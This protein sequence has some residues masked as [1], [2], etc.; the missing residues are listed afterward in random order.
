M[1]L[2]AIPVAYCAVGGIL[3][4]SGIKGATLSDT[5]RGI[6]SG[7]VNTIQATEGISINNSTTTNS[8][9]TPTGSSASGNQ[10]IGAAMGYNG[11]RYVFGGPSNPSSGW[12]CSSFASYVLGHDLGMLLPGNETWAKATNNGSTHGPVADEF[13]N[14]PRFT[15]VGNSPL[16]NQ[17]G[18]LLVWTGHVG[19]G[20]GNGGMFSAFDTQLGTLSTKASAPYSY[21]GTYRVG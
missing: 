9:A 3:V 17:P 10:I 16:N 11:H 18:D 1:A 13:A 14:T 8:G 2:K 5:A 21:V 4:F 6:L 12:D 7:N 15:K 20:T 19:F